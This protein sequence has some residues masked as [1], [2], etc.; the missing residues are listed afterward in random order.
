MLLPSP[1]APD[2]QAIVVRNNVTVHGLVGAP[3]I[4]FA[5]GF[6]CDQGMFRRMLPF[7]VDSYCVV[8]FDHVGSG[9]SS[10]ASY[11]PVEYSSLDRYAADLAELVDVL[12][13]EDVTIV[14]HSVSA[15]MAIAAAA[16]RPALF[17]RLVLLAPSPSYLDDPTT[18]Y[19]GGLSKPDVAD[20]L[21]SLDENHMAWSAAMAPVVM[22]N[23]AE[24]VY[25]DE[26]ERS[27][28]LVDPIVIRTFARVSFLSDVRGLLGSVSVPSLILQCSDDALAPPGVGEYLHERLSG[29]E[30]VVLKATG[31]VPHVSAPEETSQAILRYL[32]AP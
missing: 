16:R 18:G 27:F 29:S 9:G 4:V 3:V 21:Q 28:C 19:V 7:F 30:L 15:M 10:L 22:G 14:A 31:H 1:V 32:R 25:A 13:L 24:P 20:L 12:E 23:T 17:S 26:L 8:L 6:G 2:A 5:H 11:D